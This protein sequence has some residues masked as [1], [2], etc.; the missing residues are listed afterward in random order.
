MPRAYQT[1][2]TYAPSRSVGISSNA[3]KYGNTRVV[4]VVVV[5]VIAIAGRLLAMTAKNGRRGYSSNE[6]DG[7]GRN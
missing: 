7:N 6:D 5:V 4:V 2:A 1:S 3:S